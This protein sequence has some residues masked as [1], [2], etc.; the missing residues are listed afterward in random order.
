MRKIGYLVVLVF[1]LAL[2]SQWTAIAATTTPPPTTK[3]TTHKTTHPA[4]HKITHKPAQKAKGPAAELAKV[5]L[6]D[7]GLTLE[8]MT[9]KPGKVTFKATNHGKLVHAFQIK[10]QGLDKKTPDIVPGADQTDYG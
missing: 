10:G 2:V 7:N 8:P 1:V 4:V 6:A 5:K 3:A 9:V